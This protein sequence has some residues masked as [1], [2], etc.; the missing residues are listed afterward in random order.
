MKCLKQNNLQ[1]V[2]IYNNIK[3]KIVV[4][5]K[6]SIKPMKASKCSIYSLKASVSDKY[7]RWNLH[8]IFSKIRAPCQGIKEGFVC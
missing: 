3:Y 7:F 4:A 5:F 6:V 8:I 2:K 1:Q